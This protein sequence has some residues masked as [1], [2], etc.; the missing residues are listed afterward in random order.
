M[1]DKLVNVERRPSELAIAHGVLTVAR[2]QP[3]VAVLPL[4]LPSRRTI[5]ASHSFLLTMPTDAAETLPS[6][7]IR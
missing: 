1:R 5:S 6:R 4:Q 7:S 2:A 3:G